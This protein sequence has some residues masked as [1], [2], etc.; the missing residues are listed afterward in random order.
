MIIQIEILLISVILNNDI[1]TKV[2]ITAN[3]VIS[4][5]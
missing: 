3:N 4:K 2:I 5:E 1:I